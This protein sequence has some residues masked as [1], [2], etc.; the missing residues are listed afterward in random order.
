[1]E[2]TAEI[3]LRR[4]IG[5]TRRHIAA[6]F[7]I[8]SASMGVVGDCLA[9]SVGVADRGG[10][11]GV[12]GLDSVLDPLRSLARASRR[13]RDRSAVRSL[14]CLARCRAR[15]GRKRS[16]TRACY[17]WALEKAVSSTSANRLPRAAVELNQS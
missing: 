17:F 11:L 3:G 12:S 9:S 2:R 7:L 8:E 14:P 10:C 16:D 5:A 4:A 1:M 13:R 6:Q 15:A